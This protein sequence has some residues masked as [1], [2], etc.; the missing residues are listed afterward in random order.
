MVAMVVGALLFAGLAT[1]G[2]SDLNSIQQTR[3]Q[4]VDEVNQVAH[5]IGEAVPTG[6][7][8]DSLAVL[9]STLK[10]LK[11]PLKLQGE[12][13]VGIDPAGHFYN[14]LDTAKPVGAAKVRTL[15][16]SLSVSD[17]ETSQLFNGLPVSGHHGR[18]V[19]AAVLV[20]R[21]VP[22]SATA[23]IDLAVVLTRNAPS[24][25]GSAG[26]WFAVAAAATIAIALL[27]AV[28]LGHRIA[29]PLQEVEG[30]TRRI[31]R[32]DLEARV[33]VP[34]RREGTELVSLASSVNQMAASLARAQGAQQQ[35]LMSVS[36]DLRTPMT[37]VRGF[38]E[39][40]SDGAAD[41][42]GYAAG[43]ISSEARRLERLV[44]DLLDLAKLESGA[45]SL[46]CGPVDL[47]DIV[48]DATRAFEPAA[49]E[50]GLDLSIETTS[51]GDVYCDA[52]PD[53]LAQVV[54]N[55]VE[56]AL[57]YARTRVTVKIGR[58]ERG[59]PTVRVEDDGPGIP[60]QDLERVFERMY[61]SRL[62]RDRKKS[63]GL[64]LAIVD[65]LVKRMGGHV[66]AE[67]PIW[68][69]GG[70]RFVIV[71]QAASRKAYSQ[72]MQ[73]WQHPHP[74]YALAG[75][76]V[77]GPRRRTTAETGWPRGRL[78]GSGGSGDT[79]SGGTGGSGGSGDTAGTGGTASGGTG[80]TADTG[81]TGGSGD[82][83]DTGGSGASGD[84][85]SGASGDEPGN[86]SAPSSTKPASAIISRSAEPGAPSEVR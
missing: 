43:V 68:P 72:L 29:R 84:T 7:G 35:F 18:L 64:G 85:V 55:V 34:K 5:G 69:G 57:K 19:W 50:R 30:V 9:R 52:D 75:T 44:S 36:H 56:N 42:V 16:G 82:T 32:G 73:E 48:T 17:I 80:D 23:S 76:S 20:N 70:T 65:E 15:P 47:A 86:G 54:A 6:K 81:G 37:S 45:F 83:A 79:A 62:P 3:S 67:S 58:F 10:V 2:L 22:I 24:G 40:I 33:P 74:A 77:P 59:M 46:Q 12:A 49:A 39:A 38:A 66:R 21:P 71:L 53:R 28:R 26:L 31:A 60:P 11:A 27:V 8:P 61:Q 13:V 25:V 1:L 63:S 4:L 41:D 14:P 78:G 51:D